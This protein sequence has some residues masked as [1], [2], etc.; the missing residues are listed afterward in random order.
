MDITNYDKNDEKKIISKI[1]NG[2]NVD[3]FKNNILT[4]I[5]YSIKDKDNNVI[6]DR[7][8]RTGDKIIFNQ[9]DNNVEYILS[10]I[11]D[12]QGDGKVD[13]KDI[14]EISNLIIDNKTIGFAYEKAADVNNSGKVDVKD[15]IKI[16]NYI[17]DRSE[18]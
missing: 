16:A 12:V 15:I 14:I 6:T 2:T 5:S 9:S 8:L 17:V 1:V 4:N 7:N 18:L 11:G 13:V 10:V 3:V